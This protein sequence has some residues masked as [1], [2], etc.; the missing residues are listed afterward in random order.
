MTGQTNRLGW[1][2][3]L[4]AGSC[5][6][7]AFGAFGC[8]GQVS[9]PT[10]SVAGG[11]SGT[12][13]DSPGLGGTG[14]PG[15]GGG[16][17]PG[18]PGSVTL[19][20]GRAVIRRL[21]HT[22]YN[23]TV[24]DLL[25]TS[26]TP[27][28]A[29]PADD[30]DVEGFD[31][32]GQFLTAPPVFFETM[33]GVA[34]A[35]AD[36]LFALPATDARRTKVFVCAMTTGAEATCAKQILT[37]FA[38]RA[39][40]RPPKTAEIDGL[41][42]LVDTVRAGGTYTDGLKAAITEIL[43]SPHFLYREETSVGVGANGAAKPLN[44]FELATRLSYFF[45]S[46]MPD[47]ALA[48]SADSGK[49]TSDPAELPAQIQRMLADPKV[50]ALTTNFA[51]EWLTLRRLDT[52]DIN[53]TVYG[54]EYDDQLRAAAKQE[55]TTFFAKLVS[56]NLPLSTL[57]NADFTYANARLAKLY[58]LTATG[59]S[60]SRVSLAGTPRA[61]V[62]TQASFLMGNSHPDRSGPVQRGD[63]ILNRILCAATPPP[64]DGIVI[65][66]LPPASAGISGRNFLEAHR[67]D[68]MCASCH[69][70]I[71]PLGLGF[72]NF[73]AVG[74]YRTLD[75]GAPVNSSGTYPGGPA[76]TSATDLIQLIAKDPRYPACVTR[77]LLTYAVGR[78]FSASDGVTYA[79]ELS[80]QA[81]GN[82]GGQWRSLIAMIAS[83]EAFRTNRPDA[84]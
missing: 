40:R 51:T 45:W 64:P 67:A 15:L 46:T 6:A 43:L 62:L 59:T 23:N 27:G 77:H 1:K 31:T 34:S 11:P 30:T 44:A 36:E 69:N 71:D 7:V 28:D 18:Q 19:D 3:T 75:S 68:P 70:L 37:T 83:S 81:M 25:G 65:P 4:M 21:N 72:E 22:E 16:G 14:T 57:V 10:R 54:T 42:G 66:T 84:Q 17:G 2:R 63:W 80:A 50:T 38:R 56:D 73:D 48:A 82:G 52:P 74:A 9:G 78:T 61:G 24:H 20:S 58:G 13:A 26:L 35:L 33:E 12:G 55:T 79:Q 5:F 47:D 29:L 41:M 8:T 39:F 49:L 76:F 60:L 53:T 32:V